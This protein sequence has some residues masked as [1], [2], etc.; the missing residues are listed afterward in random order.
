MTYGQ[1]T[2]SLIK[3]LSGHGTACCSY[4]SPIILVLKGT[5]DASARSMR[6]CYQGDELLRG[7]VASLLAHE[8]SSESFLVTPAADVVAAR[9]FV[10]QN[11]S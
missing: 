2:S 5:G 3:Q 1:M 9:A 7:E 10:S 11:W 4:D 6:A 8:A